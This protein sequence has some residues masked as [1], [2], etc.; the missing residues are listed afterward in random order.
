MADGRLFMAAAIERCYDVFCH[1]KQENGSAGR[2]SNRRVVKL[3]TGKLK[4]ENWPH[5]RQTETSHILS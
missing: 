2:W 3:E 4:L 1:K 5:G